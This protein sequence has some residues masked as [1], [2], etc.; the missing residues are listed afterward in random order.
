M[1]RRLYSLL[2]Y[3]AVPFAFAAVLWRGLRDRGY[4]QAPGERFGWGRASAG[5][6]IWGSVGSRAAGPRIEGALSAA[7]DG[8]D[9]RDSHR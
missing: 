3:L 9:H 5:G 4:W 8:A 1:M 2:I 7:P 6:S